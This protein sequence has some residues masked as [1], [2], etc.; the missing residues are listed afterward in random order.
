MGQIFYQFLRL[1]QTY[2]SGTKREFL[3]ELKRDC[4]HVGHRKHKQ[5]PVEEENKAKI[6]VHTFIKKSLKRKLEKLRT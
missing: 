1:R 3:G 6:T 2:F 5:E 4:R